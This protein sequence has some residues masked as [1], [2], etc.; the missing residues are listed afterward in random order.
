MFT[1]ELLDISNY[2]FQEVLLGDNIKAKK[3]KSIKSFRFL[4][5]WYNTSDVDKVHLKKWDRFS[6]IEA[7]NTVVA[8][9]TTRISND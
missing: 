7:E 2:F 4:G 9:A 1:I 5:F 3:I 6:K 8:N